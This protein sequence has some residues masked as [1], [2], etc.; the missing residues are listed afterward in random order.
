MNEHLGKANQRSF[1]G[2]F[3]W[4]VL[5]ALLLGMGVTFHRLY[6]SEVRDLKAFEMPN[7]LLCILT[8]SA[9]AWVGLLMTV[10]ICSTRLCQRAAWLLRRLIRWFFSWRIIK[11][12]LLVLAG[13][14]GLALL[15]RVEENWRGKRTWENYRREWEA[16][17]EHFDFAYFV[18]P[19][20]PDDQNF[21]LTPIVASCYSH[22]LDQKGHQLKLRDTESENTDVANRLAMNIYRQKLPTGTNLLFGSWQQARLTDLQTWQEYYR[23][24]FLTNEIPMWAPTWTNGE[25]SVTKIEIEP[26]A[27]N[28]FPTAPQPQTPAADVLLALSK[29]DAAIEELRQASRLPYSRFPLGY[30]ISEPSAMIFPHYET[31]KD[32]VSTLRFRAVA[33]LNNG[34][35]EKALADVRLILY[36]ADSIRNE[37]ITLPLRVRMGILDNAIQPVWEGLARRQWADEQLIALEHQ[38]AE[39]DATSDYS[40]TLRS[41]LAWNL[42]SFNYVLTSR[43]TNSFIGCPVCG[44]PFW[45]NFLIRLLPNGWFHLNKVNMARL[46]QGKLPTGEESHQRTLSPAIGRRYWQIAKPLLASSTKLDSGLFRAFWPSDERTVITCARTQTS[47]DFARVAC[48]LERFRQANGSFPESLA[49]LV[50]VFIQ[51]LPHDVI[52]GQPLHYRRT[53]DGGFLLYSVGWNEKDDGG[54]RDPTLAAQ[55]RSSLDQ[56]SVTGDWVWCY[57]TN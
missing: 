27:T 11:R 46:C 14:L 15:F 52:N 23:A 4:L 32:V 50:P 10:W 3:C 55:Y 1:R 41:D 18:P 31:L 20:V 43:S 16:K 35:A 12:C 40:R 38:L 49:A 33:E 29:Y 48:A 56:L 47:V 30:A 37:P 25:L 53:S 24:A 2:S 22:V 6:F 42:K 7:I 19:P 45:P 39:L 51:K 54:E 44:Q 5:A 21:A 13:F 8:Y 36:L 28:E 57:P 26:L 9:L 17:G 34:Q